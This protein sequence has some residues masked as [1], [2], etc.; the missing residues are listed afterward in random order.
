MKVID[1]FSGAGGLS[2]GFSMAGFEVLGGVDFDR[3]ALET[4][5]RNFPTSRTWLED[6]VTPS[7]EYLVWLKNA[8]KQVDGVIGGPPCQGFSIAGKRDPQ[9]PRNLLYQRFLD[10]VQS[11]QP[12]FVVL[13]NEPSSSAPGE[14]SNSHSQPL[15]PTSSLR[16][17]WQSEIC[18][19]LTIARRGRKPPI[20]LRPPILTK[21]GHVPGS[22]SYRITSWCVTLSKP[23][24]SSQW[25][26][27]GVTTRTCPTTYKKPAM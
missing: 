26:R 21:N 17:R 18:R 22:G 19:A 20:E 9:D 16:L 7:K 15:G 23:R 6:L 12:S 25:C 2:L 8:S 4:F 3:Q 1:L 27:M 11:T 14:V 24:I 5:Q 13:E 10:T